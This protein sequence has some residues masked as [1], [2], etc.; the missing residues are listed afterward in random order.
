MSCTSF[1]NCALN[2]S[3]TSKSSFLFRYA[4]FTGTAYC[5]PYKVSSNISLNLIIFDRVLNKLNNTNAEKLLVSFNFSIL[6]FK[7]LLRGI[8]K[9]SKQ[10]TRKSCFFCLF[11]FYCSFRCNFE[12][13]YRSLDLIQVACSDCHGR[14]VSLLCFWGFCWKFTVTVCIYLL[15]S[16]FTCPLGGI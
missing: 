11:F 6:F 10:G 5:C 13:S 15:V 12:S 3:V 14:L 8:P 4:G 7:H 9:R 2:S 1:S 16:V